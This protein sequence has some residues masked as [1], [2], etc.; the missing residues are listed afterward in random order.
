MGAI[1]GQAGAALD[2]MEAGSPRAL[3]TSS[4]SD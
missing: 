4:I 1:P 2:Y 3:S